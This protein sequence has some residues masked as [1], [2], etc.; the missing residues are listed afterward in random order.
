MTPNL[1]QQKYFIFP[2]NV[3][4]GTSFWK[5]LCYLNYDTQKYLTAF[6]SQYTT[7]FRIKSSLPNIQL[8]LDLGIPQRRTDDN[9]PVG[10][11]RSIVPGDTVGNS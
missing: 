11:D 3:T 6:T 10:W 2:L 5:V 7:E 4:K 8:E 1:D 9:I